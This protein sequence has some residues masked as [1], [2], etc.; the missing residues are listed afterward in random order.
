MIVMNPSVGQGPTVFILHLSQRNLRSRCQALPCPSP[1]V[2]SGPVLHSRLRPR[3]KSLPPSKPSL[4]QQRLPLTAR[5]IQG[6]EVSSP[7]GMIMGSASV[8]ITPHASTPCWSPM[9]RL[10]LGPNGSARA[11]GNPHMRLCTRDRTLTPSPAHKAAALAAALVRP[12]ATLRE[13]ARRHL[14]STVSRRL[15]CAWSVIR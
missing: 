15:W 11:S 14:P 2:G 1:S 6:R 3:R 8:D 9:K 5:I 4:L 13:R 7:R 12:S 10:M